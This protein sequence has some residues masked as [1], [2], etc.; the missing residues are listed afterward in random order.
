[1]IRR[2]ISGKSIIRFLTAIYVVMAL[3]LPVG[4]TEAGDE[5]IERDDYEQ[6][7]DDAFYSISDNVITFSGSGALWEESAYQAGF[8]WNT[9]KDTIENVDYTCTVT[10][11]N[12][13]KL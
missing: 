13:N 7:G 4:A 10:V 3:S 12:G 6:C 8:P 2:L 5:F 1:M 9:Y 11:K